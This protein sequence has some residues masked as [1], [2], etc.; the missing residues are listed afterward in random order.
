MMSN[1]PT[2]EYRTPAAAEPAR[3]WPDALLLGAGGGAVGFLFLCMGLTTSTGGGPTL[4][5][6]C[7]SSPLT[8]VAA[9]A[10]LAT[11]LLWAGV[12]ALLGLTE[13]GLGWRVAFAATM[14]VHYAGVVAA[15]IDGRSGRSDPVSFV[16]ALAIYLIVQAAIWLIF[17][18]YQRPPRAWPGGDPVAQPGGAGPRPGEPR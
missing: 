7:M 18:S 1:P 14:L 16:L 15:G 8:H 9:P 10:V 2:L 6:A 5:P 12:G 4:M 11:P 3:L 17:V 13:R